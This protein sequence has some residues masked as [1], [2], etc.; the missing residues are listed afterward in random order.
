[1]DRYT[2]ITEEE[3]YQIWANKKAGFTA[4]KIAED[5]FRNKIAIHRELE[6]NESD[7]GYRPKQANHELGS[8]NRSQRSRLKRLLN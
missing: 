3:R 4:L 8:V 6:R 7:G 1:M 2:Q 5:L